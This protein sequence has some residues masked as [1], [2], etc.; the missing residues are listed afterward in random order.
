M[1]QKYDTSI[2]SGYNSS[3]S[4]VINNIQ[5][6]F[7]SIRHRYLGWRNMIKGIMELLDKPA[8]LRK[9]SPYLRYFTTN[10]AQQIERNRSGIYSLVLAQDKKIEDAKILEQ[11]TGEILEHMLYEIDSRREQQ[12]GAKKHDFIKSKL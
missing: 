10:I 7:I 6:I 2:S 8:E 4:D 1:F 12:Q 11:S 5:D 9:N 3:N